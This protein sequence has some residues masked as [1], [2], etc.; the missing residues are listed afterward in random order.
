MGGKDYSGSCHCGAVKFSAG[1]DLAA[2]TGKCNCS[3]CAKSRFWGTM[4]KADTFKLL[5]GEDNLSDY[6]FGSHGVHWL[7]CKTCG[8]RTFY[9][10]NIEQMGGDMVGV[11][12]ACLDNASDLELAETPVRFADG[13][14][15]DWGKVPAETRHL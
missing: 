10:T 4:I 13:R 1:I 8:I 14:N 9:K 3:I 11:N 12:L 7:F 5:S 2:G 6:H 15:N